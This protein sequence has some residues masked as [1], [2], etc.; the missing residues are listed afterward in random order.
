MGS[1]DTLGC[2]SV[3]PSMRPVHLE[4]PGLGLPTCPC[5]VTQGSSLL[6]GVLAA[7]LWSEGVCAQ[8][9]SY[10]RLFCS[11]V[12]CSW[13]GSSVHGISQTRILEWVAISFSRGFS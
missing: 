3:A 7:P 9:I 5:A 10:I 2:E 12:D 1:E 13:P 11:P 6:L 4:D 8:S